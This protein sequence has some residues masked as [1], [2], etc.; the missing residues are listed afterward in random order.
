V[1]EKYYAENKVIELREK[2]SSIVSKELI[3]GKIVSSVNI[4]A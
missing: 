2:L 4:F 3:C 1:D